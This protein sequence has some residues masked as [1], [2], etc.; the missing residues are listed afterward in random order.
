MRVNRGLL[1][2]GVFFIT[3]GTIPLAVRYGVLDAAIARRSIELWPLILV[4]IGLGLALQ[5]TRAAAV[6]GV[7]V[8]LTFGLIGGGLVAGGFGPSGG[9]AL[10]GFGGEGGGAQARPAP[11]RAGTFGTAA[12][13][14]LAA[15]CGSL[16]IDTA[17]G[18]D[19]SVTGGA[20]DGRPPVITASDARLQLRAADRRGLGISAATAHWAVIL[21]RDPSLRL[22]LSVNA[23][24]MTARLA[25]LHVPGLG[26]SVNAGDAHLDLS[27]VV[28]AA[29]VSGSVNFG[30]LAIS[31][32]TPAAALTGTLST[33]AGSLE[34]CVPAGVELRFRAGDHALGSDNFGDRGLTEAGGTWTTAGFDAATSRIDLAVSANL[35]SITLNPED[36]CG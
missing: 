27:G 34:I 21:P 36:G 30:S 16:A 12:S 2:W 8:A 3:L 13:V 14:D 17:P 32:P 20:D 10:C 26:V 1:G 4:G 22:D 35:G 19:W 25:G 6:G 5:R 7:V 28:D 23:G 24:S 31:L 29:S 18:S 9:F 11:S 15:D 33:N